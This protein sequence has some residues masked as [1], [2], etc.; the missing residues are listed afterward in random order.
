LNFKDKF[1]FT[2]AFTT[3]GISGVFVNTNIA[4]NYSL[5]N[6]TRLIVTNFSSV[7]QLVPLDNYAI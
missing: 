1:A 5:F 6:D 7:D 3:F 4:G 2:R